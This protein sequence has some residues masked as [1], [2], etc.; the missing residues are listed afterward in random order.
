MDVSFLYY[1]PEKKRSIT[2]ANDYRVEK[3]FFEKLRNFKEFDFNYFAN[4]DKRYW[5]FDVENVWTSNYIMLENKFWWSWPWEYFYHFRIDDSLFRVFAGKKENDETMYI[6]LIDPKG[7][8]N[9]K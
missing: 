2:Y 6:L 7:E 3:K 9:H 8:E 4:R 1:I 5:W